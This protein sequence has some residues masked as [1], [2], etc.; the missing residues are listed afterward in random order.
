MNVMAANIMTS[1]TAKIRG[2]TKYS[3]P[4]DSS[5]AVLNIWYLPVSRVSRVFTIVQTP[6]I[7][8]PVPILKSIAWLRLSR[9]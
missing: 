5:C 2:E 4:A 9:I 3:D 8:M 7:T 1:R 6:K